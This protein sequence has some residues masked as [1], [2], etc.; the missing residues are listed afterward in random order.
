[1]LLLTRKFKQSV[2]TILYTAVITIGFG[3][4]TLNAQSCPGLSPRIHKITAN[5]SSTIKSYLEFKPLDYDTHPTRKYAL[6]VYEGGTG[7]MFQQP[8]G[9]DADLCPVVGY[10]MPFRMNVGQFPDSVKAPNGQWYSY[11]VVMPFVTAWEQQYSVDP[12]PMI[13]YVLQHYPNRIDVTRIY[14]TAMSRGTDNIM[15]YVTGSL[16][17]ARRIAAI[18]PVANCFPAFT[19]T[20]GYNQQVANLANSGLHLWGVQC[21]GDR[22]CPET[23]IQAFV[24]SLNTQNPAH[25][26]FSYATTYCNSGDSTYHYA[27]NHAYSPEEFRPVQSGGKNIYEWMIQFSQN[28]L[29]P[30]TLKNWDARYERGSVLLDWTTSQELNTKEF[31]IQRGATSSNFETILTVP[32][33]I[34]SSADKKYSAVDDHPLPGQSFYR[35]ISTDQDGKQTI[36]AVRSIIVPGNWK[37]NVIIPNPINN[38]NL[39]V[40][41][42]VSKNQAVDIRLFDLAGRLLKQEH[43]QLLTGV[44]QYSFDV[45]ALQKGSY[46]VQ[47]VGEDFKTSRKIS[48]E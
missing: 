35:L 46:V 17:N 19:G 22:L 18:V 12:G 37:D 36:S 9:S 7:E 48:I 29:L 33:A 21:Q 15:G 39:S 27:W 44:T 2:T 16:A 11:F 42:N 30:I 24:S 8:G 3:T 28:S 34:A 4:N 26:I 10:S 25:A 5:V 38:G 32:A 23:N 40:Y 43:K 14:L 6:I 45:T 20:T 13:D 47:I 31:L 1:M 41:L